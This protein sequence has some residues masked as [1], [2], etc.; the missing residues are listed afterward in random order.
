MWARE[1]CD[2]L[3]V[4][5]DPACSFGFRDFFEKN[6]SP[7]VAEIYD[8]HRQQ[9]QLRTVLFHLFEAR[10]SFLKL[11][12]VEREDLSHAAYFESND[13]FFPDVRHVERA[14]SYVYRI[15]FAT[16][17][18]SF[19]NFLKALYSNEIPVIFRHIQIQPNYTFKLVKNNESQ[20]LECLASTFSVTLEILDFPQNISRHGKKNAALQRKIFYKNSD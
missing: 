1:S 3:G 10:S 17:T 8:I 6:E 14:K 13:V 4:E 9:E 15:K 2:A 19:R 20:I 7:L 12:S 11:F 18:N 5:F 16:F